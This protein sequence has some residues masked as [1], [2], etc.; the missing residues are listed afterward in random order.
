MPIEFRCAN[1]HKLLRTPDDTAGQTGKCPHCDALMRI[2]ARDGSRAEPGADGGVAQLVSGPVEILSPYASSEGYAGGGGYV[3]SGLRPHHGAISLTFGLLS[4]AFGMMTTIGCTCCFPIGGVGA[5]VSIGFGVPAIVIG[6]QDLKA[7]KTG[8][9][10]ASGRSQAMSGM[11]LGIVGI[12]LVVLGL[13]FYVL[14]FALQL[15]FMAATAG[16]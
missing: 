7:I 14:V 15:G 11:V 2:P 1:C 5:A 8:T 10:D 13:V 16:P 6:M 9:M 4:M 3:D 12:V